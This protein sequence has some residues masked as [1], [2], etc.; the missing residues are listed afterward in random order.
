MAAGAEAEHDGH[1][2]GSS[3]ETRK[4]YDDRGELHALGMDDANDAAAVITAAVLGRSPDP[5]T[6]RSRA[7]GTADPPGRPREPE[8]GHWSGAAEVRAKRELSIGGA[9]GEPG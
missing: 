2:P 6:G 8:D 1:R 9:A 7:L 4:G 5:A 3:E